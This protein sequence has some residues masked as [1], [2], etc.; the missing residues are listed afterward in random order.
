MRKMKGMNKWQLAVF[1]NQQVHLAKKKY[2]AS[3]GTRQKCGDK[4]L[5]FLIR[6]SMSIGVKKLQMEDCMVLD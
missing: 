4:I 3:L 1:S 2:R 6:I 5:F